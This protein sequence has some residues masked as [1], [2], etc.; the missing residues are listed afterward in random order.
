MYKKNLLFCFLAVF[1][2]HVSA[3]EVVDSFSQDVQKD[4]IVSNIKETQENVPVI[5]YSLNSAYKKYTIADIK[6]AGVEHFGYEDYVLIG[7]SGLS[8]GDKVSVPGEE[9]TKALKAFLKHGLFSWGQ[10]L[11]TKQTTDSVWLEIALKPN[12][13]I[14]Q[15]EFSGVKK[16]EKEDLETKI[17]LSKGTQLT[18]NIINRA[19]KRTKDYFDEKGFSNAEV[20]VQ[21]RDD[22]SQEGRVILDIIV[23]K[24]AKTKVGNIYIAGNEELSDYELKMAMK[25]TNE[26]FSLKKR[27]RLSLRKMFSTKKF[28]KDEY[29]NDLQNLLIK[30]NEKGYRDAYIL[31]DSIVPVDDKHVDIYLKVHEGDKFY[32]RSINWVGNTKYPSSTLDYLLDLHPGDVYN[33][34]KLLERL[35]TDE[36]AVANLYFNNGYIFSDMD[37]VEVNVENDSID[38][39][40]RIREGIQAT[41]NKIVISGNDRIYEDII[42][43]E[44]MTKP[45]Q[46]FSKEAL[47]NSAREIAQMGHFDPE[48]MDIQTIPDSETGTVDIT[49]NLTPKA[50]DQ[51]E[52][53]AGWGQ[54]G[55]IGRLS[56]RFTN[57]S[58]N[59]LFNPSS[60]KG[61]LPQG[62]GQTLT[63]SGQTNGRYYQSYSISFL[64]PWFGGKRPNSFSLS[65]FYMIQTGIESRSFNNNYYNYYGYGTDYGYGYNNLAYDDNRSMKIFGVTAGYGKRLS[66]PDIYFTLMADVSYQRYQMKNWQYFVV[67]N[68]NANS[69]AFGLT[70]GR[71]SIDNPLY[72]RS[73]STFAL[74]VNATPP[75]SLWDGVDYGSLSNTDPRM[76]KWIEYHKWKFKGKLF[77]PLANKE[78]VKR[79]PVLMSRMEYGFVGTYN[80]KKYNPFETFYVG[81]DGMSGYST[82]YANEMVGLRGYEAGAL[83]PYQDGYAYTRLALELRYP[84]ML[85]QSSTIYALTFVE[86]GNAWSEVKA[87]NPFDLKRSAGFGVRVFLPMIGLLGLDW[88][89]GFDSPF[90]G[91]PRTGSKMHFVLGQEF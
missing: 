48:N 65:A 13:L 77:I 39:E 80:S 55:V 84:L 79:T 30:Y 71:S 68:G 19:K 38:V 11:A 90:P 9:I 49:Y 23:D 50:N 7:I 35:Q 22:L 64:D 14:S 86:A 73:G 21:Q 34:K 26:G 89:Y 42:R 20:R 63:L 85:E 40:I 6:V 44:L 53:S 87:F 52:F 1:I 12:P 61:F 32:I 43:R 81:G 41:M 76:Y 51:I 29:E 70:L 24:N 17:G 58:V 60:Y 46:L 59:N 25:K 15:I 33:Q 54:T 28:V 3:Q 27:P 78:K 62:E 74:S 8:V 57:F 10:I 2:A 4:T 45:G 36:D 5:T 56:L 69:L 16:G 75:Y 37:P 31:S 67:Q 88:A 91:T 47:M 72:T 18:P 82:M 83:T 66:W